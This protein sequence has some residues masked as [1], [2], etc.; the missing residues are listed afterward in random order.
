MVEDID[1]LYQLRFFSWWFS[2]W[3]MP[4]FVISIR[5]RKCFSWQIL[6]RAQENWNV[7]RQTHFQIYGHLLSDI[8][9]LDYDK[10]LNM[11]SASRIFRQAEIKCLFSLLAFPKLSLESMYIDSLWVHL[12][13]RRSSKNVIRINRYSTIL[14]W[15]FKLQDEIKIFMCNRAERC[16][17]HG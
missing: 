4:R 10:C 16:M 8:S 13:L 14:A 1:V 2:P 17:L 11:F 12:I 3:K 6:K 15:C 7:F 5:M 9:R